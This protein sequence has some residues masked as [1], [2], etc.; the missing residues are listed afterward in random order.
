MPRS[1]FRNRIIPK[2]LAKRGRW[3]AACFSSRRMRPLATIV[4][5]RSRARGFTLTELMI[6][7]VIIGILASMAVIGV[8]RYIRYSKITEAGD[9]ITAIKEAQE[10]YRDERLR[11]LDVSNGST[12]LGSLYPRDPGDYKS[13]WW[14]SGGPN[15]QQW[16]TLSAEAGGPVYFG[17]ATAAGEGA[18]DSST[19]PSNLNATYSVPADLQGTN[20]P[21][22]VVVAMSDL[23]GDGTTYGVHVS[24]SFTTEIY[25]EN[26]GE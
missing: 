10:S 12:S 22:F 4:S 18:F 25:T 23:D 21:W 1:T 7:V 17:Y 8:T 11:Y 14:N 19:L 3:H 9:M 15:H 5:K 13:S 24:S 16:R 2:K 20:E 26:E 6:V